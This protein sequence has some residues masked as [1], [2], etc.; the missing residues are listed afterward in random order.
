MAVTSDLA[1]RARET[2]EEAVTAVA[3]VAIAITTDPVNAIVTKTTITTDRT[4]APTDPDMLVDTVIHGKQRLVARTRRWTS[5]S[6]SPRASSDTRERNRTN[7]KSDSLD[8]RTCDCRGSEVDETPGDQQE[9]PRERQRLQLQP[10]TKPLEEFQP[11]SG[12]SSSVN[13]V[14]ANAAQSTTSNAD[15]SPSST[16]NT[17][18]QADD[19]SLNEQRDSN[20]LASTTDEQ[21]TVKSARGAGASI[22]GGAKPVDTTARER[23]IEK[24]LQELQVTATE[25]TGDAEEKPAASR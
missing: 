3:A 25:T 5:P 15:E 12:S 8:Q 10:R 17:S 24:K 20:D 23:E 14:A 9:P 7:G 19:S 4:V 13:N 21:S 6:F 16:A 11:L 22:F 1:T 18:R 2:I